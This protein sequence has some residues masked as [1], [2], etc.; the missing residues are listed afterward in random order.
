MYFSG[1]FDL[2]IYTPQDLNTP[3]SW[4]ES[5]PKYISKSNE[6]KLRSFN[7]KVRKEKKT[8]Q[9]ITLHLNITNIYRTIYF[10]LIFFFLFRFIKLKLQLHI[11]LMIDLLFRL[12][13]KSRNSFVSS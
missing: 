12:K 10:L 4:E 13:E 3:I 2:L 7:T 9:N 8:I 11:E 5:D 1:T 6:V